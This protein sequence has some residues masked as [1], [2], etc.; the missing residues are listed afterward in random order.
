MKGTKCYSF[1]LD[2]LLYLLL[3]C[4]AEYHVHH[5]LSCCDTSI[6]NHHFCQCVPQD[7]HPYNT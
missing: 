6:G 7:L 1:H 2:E 4:N 3:P 5:V